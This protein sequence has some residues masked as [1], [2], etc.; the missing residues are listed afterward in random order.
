MR[1]LSTLFLATA[2]ISVAAGCATDDVDSDD[3]ATADEEALSVASGATLSGGTHCDGLIVHF[4]GH[5][6]PASAKL[7]FEIG[8]GKLPISHP[9]GEIEF[10]PGG[11]GRLV[12][13]CPGCTTRT[14]PVHWLNCAGGGGGGGDPQK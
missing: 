5:V 11:S 6:S 10:N 2:L 13:S 3:V 12:A 1:T 4:S 8:G 9:G 14:L 7:V